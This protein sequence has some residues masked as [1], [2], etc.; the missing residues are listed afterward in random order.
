MSYFFNRIA[1]ILS[2]PQLPS[3]SLRSY[4]CNKCDKTFYVHDT[5]T[6]LPMCRECY[7]SL[8]IYI[9]TTNTNGLVVS[10]FDGPSNL[11]TV[12]ITNLPVKELEMNE[13]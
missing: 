12:K 7:L 6:S 10:V 4:R 3:Q 5:K 1:E 9:P 13:S 2:Y 8:P 11:T